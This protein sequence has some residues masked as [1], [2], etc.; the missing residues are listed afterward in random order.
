MPPEGMLGNCLT[1]QQLR[2]EGGMENGMGMSNGSELYPSKFPFQCFV[3]LSPHSR[4]QICYYDAQPTGR[5]TY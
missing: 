3:P 5:V 4:S 2:V 1:I